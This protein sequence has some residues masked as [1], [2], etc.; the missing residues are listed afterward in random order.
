MIPCGA[1]IGIAVAPSD[2]ETSV[3]LIKAADLA[4]YN[5]KA[6]GRHG[7]RFYDVGMH[8][9]VRERRELEQDLAQALQNCELEVHY[10]SQVNLETGK[11]DSY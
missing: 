11:I 10:Q 5:A 7:Y 9:K 3:E 1:C 8:E 4:M 2:G 6:E